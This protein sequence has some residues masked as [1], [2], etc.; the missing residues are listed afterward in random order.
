M[1]PLAHLA[2]EIA[3]RRIDVAQAAGINRDF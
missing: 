2:V 1:T 3:R